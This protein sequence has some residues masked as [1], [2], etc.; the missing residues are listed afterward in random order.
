M[1]KIAVFSVFLFLC[2]SGVFA[3]HPLVGQWKFSYVISGT[4]FYD[5]ITITTVS[6]TTKKVYGHITG[7]TSWKLSGYYNGN[8]VFIADNGQDYLLEGYYFTFQG[9]TPLKKWFAVISN[10]HDFDSYWYALSTTKLSSSTA[11]IEIMTL[12]DILNQKALKKQALLLRE[13]MTAP[14][15]PE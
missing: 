4:R 11:S 14:T 3:V 8:I 9:T 1:K 6:T 2:V 12:S 15:L 5:Y 10:V 7:L 13:R